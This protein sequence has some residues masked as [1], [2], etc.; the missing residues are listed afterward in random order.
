MLPLFR[1]VLIF[2]VLFGWSAAVAAPSSGARGHHAAKATVAAKPLKLTPGSRAIKR[3]AARPGGVAA[4]ARQAVRPAAFKPKAGIASPRAVRWT[5]RGKRGLRPREPVRA[6]LP[7]AA[8]VAEVALTLLQRA[9]IYRAIVERPIEPNPVPTERIRGPVAAAPPVPPPISQDVIP[10]NLEPA[11]T[12]G[13]EPAIG[14]PVPP[15]VPLHRIPPEAVA[16]VPGIERY[17]Y[18]FVGQ[19]VLLVDP[20]TGMVV[21]AVNQ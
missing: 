5:A 4:P 20:E 13:I 16:A 18:A 10:E 3:A 2:M 7:E 15:S 8:P 14:S 6:M 19:S 9:T 17:R 11:A 12:G 21:A 1:S